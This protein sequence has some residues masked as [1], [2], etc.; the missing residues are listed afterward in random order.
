MKNHYAATIKAATIKCGCLVA[1]R[2]AAW[3]ERGVEGGEEGGG[4]WKGFGWELY[5]LKLYKLK[6]IKEKPMVRS[7]TNNFPIVIFFPWSQ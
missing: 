7:S 1:G 4:W 6:F 5:L 3:V 2:K